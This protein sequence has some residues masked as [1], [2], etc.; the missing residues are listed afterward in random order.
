MVILL[1]FRHWTPKNS[2]HHGK[3]CLMH[4][5][6]WSSWR[7][8]GMVTYVTVAATKKAPN[9]QKNQRSTKSTRNLHENSPN[10]CRHPQSLQHL[11]WRIMKCWC[12]IRMPSD[13]SFLHSN[14]P[15]DFQNQVLSM[16]WHLAS[17]WREVSK[18]CRVLGSSPWLPRV[19]IVSVLLEIA[20]MDSQSQLKWARIPD[21]TWYMPYITPQISYS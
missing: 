5:L 11:P 2:G 4:R 13:G 16:S 15:V 20:G 8:P 9:D 21:F 17:L 7:I 12:S 19:V 10:S 3:C 14:Q 6:P 1:L 18:T